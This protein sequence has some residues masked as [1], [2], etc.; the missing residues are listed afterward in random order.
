MINLRPAKVSDAEDFVRVQHAAVHGSDPSI[1][2][3]QDILQSWSPSPTDQ[4]RLNRLRQAIE[5]S[6]EILVAAESIENAVIVGFGSLVPSK[7]EIR[8]V[9]VDPTFGSQ[10]VGSKILTYL[11]EFARLHGVDKLHL[12]ASLSAERFYCH[13]GYSVIERGNHQLS[14]GAVMNCVKM[15][16]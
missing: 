16:K 2:Y 11:E 1:F 14:S 6:E 7:Q 5:D 8:A 12:D 9:Y 13:H 4:Y 3:T 15:S 10:G